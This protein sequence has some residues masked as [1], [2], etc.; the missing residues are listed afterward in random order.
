MAGLLSIP[1][2]RHAQPAHNKHTTSA[3]QPHNKHTTE[4]TNRTSFIEG[5][6]TALKWLSRQGL[7]ETGPDWQI[8]KMSG[9]VRFL[10]DSRLG[11]VWEGGRATGWLLGNRPT[12]LRSFTFQSPTD[13]STT[14][15]LEAEPRQMVGCVIW[16]GRV[17]VGRLIIWRISGRYKP[18]GRTRALFC[19]GRVHTTGSAT[20]PRCWARRILP[21]VVLTDPCLKVQPVRP[22]GEEAKS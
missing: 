20:Q 16:T 11:R 1:F 5:S 9:F 15:E 7:S 14:P 21:A 18:H 12:S 22:T 17:K 10:P 2:A 4:R 8:V 13:L 6:K 19:L 3:Q